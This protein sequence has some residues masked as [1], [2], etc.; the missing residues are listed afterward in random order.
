MIPPRWLKNNALFFDAVFTHDGGEPYTQEN[1]ACL[2][3]RYAGDIAWRHY[4]AVN[5]QNEVRRRT[6]L[7]LRSISAI[8]HTVIFA[9]LAS[10]QPSFTC[11]TY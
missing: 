10:F 9:H 8:G 2:F 5:G 1:A 11:L 4:E 7:V 6:D 3:E